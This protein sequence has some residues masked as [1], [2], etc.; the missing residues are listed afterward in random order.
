MARPGNLADGVIQIGAIRGNKA[1]YA[2]INYMTSVC[3]DTP[4]S[5]YSDNTS[6]RH[7][8]VG[9]SKS[10]AQGNP[11]PPSLAIAGYGFWRFRW[12]LTT[13][14]HTISCLVKQVSGGTPR[15]SL[16]VKKNAAIGLASDTT[17]TA[18]AGTGWTAIGPLSVIVTSPGVVWVELWNNYMAAYGTAYFDH[19]VT[20]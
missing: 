18:G 11:S 6:G 2:S 5:L 3:L 17:G 20:T 10:T 15:P 16:V 1:G 14:T 7:L 8:V 13:G 19:I 12:S 4:T 9:I